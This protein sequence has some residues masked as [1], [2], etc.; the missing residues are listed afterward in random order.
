MAKETFYFTHDYNARTDPKI[1]KL[2]AKHGYTGYGIFWSL[3]EDLYNNENC[4]PAQFDTISFDLR[5]T[6]DLVRSVIS[7]FGLFIVVGDSFGSL[8]VQ[9]RLDDRADKSKKARDSAMRRWAKQ[10]MPEIDFTAPEVVA[11]TKEIHAES[12][13]T[14]CERIENECD[15]NAIKE[16]KEKEIK[17]NYKKLLLSEIKISDT[18]EINSDYLEVAK[19]FHG[20]FKNNLI[21]A[22]AT[23]INIEKAKG[24]WID[25]IR[26]II[27]TDKYTIEDLR[28]VYQL[29]QKNEF[30]K[31]NILSTSKLR[32]KMDNL[33]LEIKNGTNKSVSKEGTSWDAL[34]GIVAGAFATT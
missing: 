4:L 19:S 25:D 29:L 17:V 24:T 34:A 9:K 20:L 28:A 21:E 3:V 15:R 11:K 7:D 8:S 30:W 2:I 22:G 31:K 1:K 16:K 32:E 23:L 6:E 13:P 33:K 27:E 14:Q 12:M 26:M 18:P 5:C 10:T